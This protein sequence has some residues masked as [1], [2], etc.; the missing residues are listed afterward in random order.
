MKLEIEITED[1]IRS[2]IE[3]KVRVAVADQTNQWA[4]DVYIQN[5]VKELWKKVADAMIEEA[6]RDSANMKS[7]IA[8]ELERRIRNQLKVA[9][10][11][12]A[13]E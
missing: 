8:A 10:K 11:N 5:T 1:E 13:H 4:V 6:L 7:K 9:L 3:R 12:A 2:A